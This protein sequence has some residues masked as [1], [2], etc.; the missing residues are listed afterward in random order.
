MN[1]FVQSHPSS[2]FRHVLMAGRPDRGARMTLRNNQF[3]RYERGELTEQRSI[4]TPDALAAL[5][6]D[7]FRI[8]LPAA[9]GLQPLLEGIASQIA[10]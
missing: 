10:E 4:R 1:H 8:A 9:S 3:R 7:E 6:R 2:H 5:L